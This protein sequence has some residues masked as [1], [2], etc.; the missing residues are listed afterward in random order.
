MKS[1]SP[2]VAALNVDSYE[3]LMEQAPA[4]LAAIEAEMSVGVTP[5]EVKRLILRHIGPE[6][7]AT[8]RRAFQAAQHIME[9][10]RD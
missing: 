7:I 2:I 6:R 4:L 5:D 9:S 8:A 3:Y 10:Q 1:S